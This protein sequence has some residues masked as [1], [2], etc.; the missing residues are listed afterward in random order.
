MQSINFYWHGTNGAPTFTITFRDADTL[1]VE[2][3]IAVA[4]AVAGWNYVWVDKTFNARRLLVLVTGNYDDQV[5]LD[6]S[7]F[8]LDNFGGLNWGTSGNGG[9]LNYNY[10]GCGCQCRLNGLQYTSANNQQDH[11]T[12]TFGLSCV[13]SAKCTWDSFVC[14][15]KRHFAQVWLYCLAIEYFNF[16]INSSRLNRWT[17][18]DLEQAI[19]LRDLMTLKYRGGTDSGSDTKKIKLTYPGIL[20]GAI[21]SITISDLDCCVKSNNYIIWKEIIP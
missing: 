20:K 5:A 12:N 11:V 4:A 10:G 15:N 17:T 6:I 13:F 14:T 19:T 1:A 16:R 7:Q 21:E 9:W 3:T 18:T 2:S 8:Q